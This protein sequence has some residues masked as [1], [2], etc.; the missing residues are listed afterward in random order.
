[1]RLL[2]EWIFQQHLQTGSRVTLR[3]RTLRYKG[4]RVRQEALGTGLVSTHSKRTIAKA[5]T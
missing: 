3:T 1:M 5:D 2:P 4:P